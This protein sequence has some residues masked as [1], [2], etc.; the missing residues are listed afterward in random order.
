MKLSNLGFISKTIERSQEK[1]EKHNFEIRKHL[2][3]YDDVL[4]QQ[5]IVIYQYRLDALNGQEAI[6]QLIRDFII[7]II[8]NVVEKHAPKR[9]IDRTNLHAIYEELSTL[10][11]L[12][13]ENFQEQ[14]F[15]E[16]NSDVLQKDLI[17]FLLSQYD[18]Y[19]NQADKKMIQQA[20]KWLVLETIDQVW[21]QHMLNLDHLKEGIGLRG[22]GQKNPLVEYKREA[23]ALFRD[24]MEHIRKSV[25]QH[26]FHLNIER[27]NQRET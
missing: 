24:M 22:W 23:Y 6:Y 3:E 9:R 27:F 13:S 26:M 7:I 5:R 21:K 25:V 17:D 12:S 11:R 1:V 19:R 8:E 2:L 14:G 4:N 20:E 10:S 18:L 16:Q 15:N